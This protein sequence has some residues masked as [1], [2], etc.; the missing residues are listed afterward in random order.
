MK[1]IFQNPALNAACLILVGIAALFFI[2]I[3][4]KNTGCRF[5]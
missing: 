4:Q 1:R 3:K 2:L 5:Q